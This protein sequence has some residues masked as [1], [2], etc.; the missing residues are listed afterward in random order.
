M[1]RKEGGEIMELASHAEHDEFVS[2]VQ[3]LYGE[4]RN[5]IAGSCSGWLGCGRA[6][7][8]VLVVLRPVSLRGST[9][10]VSSD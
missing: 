10:L 4:A 3:P 1:I 8:K 7:L 2:A 5:I 6:A 9:A